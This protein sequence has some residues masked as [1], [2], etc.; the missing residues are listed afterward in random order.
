[1]PKLKVFP[2]TVKVLRICTQ[3]R[4]GACEGTRARLETPPVSACVG[5]EVLQSGFGFTILD[6]RILGKVS[7]NVS[8][9]FSPE[10]LHVFPGFQPPP[11]QKKFAPRIHT[12]NCRHSSP[13]SL[14]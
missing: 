2:L 13:I 3:A 1:M 5:A 8:A 12:Q 14:V 9:N 10:I 4:G 11:P 6:W 7:A